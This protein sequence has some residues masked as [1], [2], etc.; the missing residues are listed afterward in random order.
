VRGKSIVPTAESAAHPMP[1][2]TAT[3]NARTRGGSNPGYSTPMS[4]RRR[5]PVVT[6]REVFQNAW[7]LAVALR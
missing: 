5:S 4:A 6:T 2:P 7:V 3:P 1:K